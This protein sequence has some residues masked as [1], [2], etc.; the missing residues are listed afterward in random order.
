MCRTLKKKVFWETMDRD[1]TAWVKGCRKCL[2]EN[3]RP[4]VTPPLKP[5]VSSKPFECVCADLLEM[6]LSANGMKYV[7]VVVDQFSKWLEAYAIKD[8]S[9]K[10]VAEALFQKWVCEGGR[11]PRQIHTD[12]G[13][14]F[15]NELIGELSKIAG[16]NHTVTKGYNSRE[17]GACERTIGTLQRI[18]KKKIEFPDFWD[19]MLPNAVYAYNVTPHTATGESLFFLL[20]GF[21][22]VVPMN[23][24]PEGKVQLHHIDLDDYKAELIRGMRLIQSE[25]NAHA[26]LYRN[27]IKEFHD[28]KNKVDPRR[29]P[30]VGERVFMKMPTEKAKSKHPK[31]TF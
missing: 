26:Q 17:N 30:K 2:L 12:Q 28:A 19:T 29:H 24:V 1:I 10:T 21:D 9:A 14:E 25:V 18:L 31:L 16:I 4:S 20:H 8:K 7:L 27:K 5:F 3:P 23:S 11:W 13:T 6:G 15:V 22:P